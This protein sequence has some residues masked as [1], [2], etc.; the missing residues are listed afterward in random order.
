[1]PTVYQIPAWGADPLYCVDEIV[2][3]LSAGPQPLP[4]GVAFFGG[5][6][7]LHMGIAN[8]SSV[9]E[10]T[11]T[12][13]ANIN[14]VTDTADIIVQM[15][16]PCLEPDRFTFEMPDAPV[17]SYTIAEFGAAFTF[18][19]PSYPSTLSLWPLCG[20]TSYTI[21]ADDQRVQ[22]IFTV[23]GNYVMMDSTD[24]SLVSA[25]PYEYRL[26]QSLTKFP[27]CDA[28][29][30]TSTGTITVQDACASPTYLD[31]GMTINTDTDY[32]YPAEWQF[33]AIFT[34]PWVCETYATYSCNYLEGPTMLF[35]LCNWTHPNG[36]KSHLDPV[37]GAYI[38]SITD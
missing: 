22:D 35:D 10:H 12:I 34:D 27:D 2:T 17:V 37:T 13:T 3:V 6:L 18:N 30:K 9:G 1:M 38:F 23:F 4:S 20:D 21:E 25:T 29:K 19:I 24:M 7:T 14:G 15:K 26:V 31:T 33:P 32:T 36:E 28:C 8:L 16:N 11:I 5:V